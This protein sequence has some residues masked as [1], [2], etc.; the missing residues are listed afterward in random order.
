LTRRERGWTCLPL[1]GPP[2]PSASLRVPLLRVAA[3]ARDRP[4]PTSA[5]YDRARPGLQ[6]GRRGRASP[7]FGLLVRPLAGQRHPRQSLS[8]HQPYFNRWLIS[9]E[10]HRPARRRSRRGPGVENGVNDAGTSRH[11]DCALWGRHD[12]DT[13]RSN[14][15][16]RF[17]NERPGHVGDSWR[18]RGGRRLGVLCVGR[19]TSSKGRDRVRLNGGPSQAERRRCRGPHG[20][21]SATE[22]SLGHPRR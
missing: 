15:H 18:S 19:P 14:G 4:A 20:G 17:G 6:I 1:A 8:V 2:R 3:T 7:Q 12:L 11:R 13:P 9:S 5:R 16:S 21:A 22:H 10:L